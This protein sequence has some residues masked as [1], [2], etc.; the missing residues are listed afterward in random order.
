MLRY[1]TFDS[2]ITVEFTLR[3][4]RNVA[5]VRKSPQPLPYEHAN[6]TLEIKKMKVW[7]PLRNRYECKQISL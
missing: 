1:V 6:A 2:I 3:R 7:A 5:I 4:K